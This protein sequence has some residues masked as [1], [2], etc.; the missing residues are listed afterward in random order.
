MS[1][2][3]NQCNFIEAYKTHGLTVREVAAA[4]GI[5]VST[6]RHRLLR[7]GVLRTQACAAK[8]AA[9][10]GRKGDHLK[11]KTRAVT[12]ETRQRMSDARQRW[13]VANAKGLSIKPSGYVEITTGPN[14][15]R[16]HHRVVVEQMLGRPLGRDEHVHHIDGDRTNNDPSNLVVMGASE[17]ARH[18]AHINHVRRQRDA[19]G[20][21]L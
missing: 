6:V 17:H 13:S 14:K 10:K 16:P 12:D 18:H 9:S 1:N 7:A 4:F 20:R 2:D 11:G 19:N 5:P 15:G 8:L 3:L 21:F